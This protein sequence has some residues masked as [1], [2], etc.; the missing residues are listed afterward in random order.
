VK[1]TGEISKT[2]NL[3]GRTRANDRGFTMIE[4]IAVLVI[5]GILAAVAFSR[6]SLK[7]NELYTEADLLKANLRFAQWRAMTVND[8]TSTTWG[9]GFSGNSYTLLKDGATTTLSLPS[10]DS[11]THALSA[12][13]TVSGPTVVTYDYWGSPGTSNIAVTLTKAGESTSFTIS[14][15]TGYIP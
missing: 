9:L 4:I 1:Y 14:G 10:D 3:R 8:N 12:G 2:V 7:G 6:I 5:M 15:T 11:G 13:V